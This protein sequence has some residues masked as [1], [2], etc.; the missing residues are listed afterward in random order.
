M[1]ILTAII[2]CTS[3]FAGCSQ[4]LVYEDVGMDYQKCLEK[5]GSDSPECRM[6]T[7][8][9]SPVTTRFPVDYVALYNSGPHGKNCYNGPFLN[10]LI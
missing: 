1:K 2:I 8:G 3:F 6:K 7:P 4:K 10:S 9:T 5:Y